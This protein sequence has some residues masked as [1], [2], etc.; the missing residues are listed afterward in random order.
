MSLVQQ[1]L[2]RVLTARFLDQ[3]CQDR[4]ARFGQSPG[5]MTLA[6][7]MPSREFPF[8]LDIRRH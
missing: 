6:P 7:A 1:L 8:T 4:V 5:P 3:P 2:L